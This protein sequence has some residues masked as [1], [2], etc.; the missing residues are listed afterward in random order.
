MK[1]KF[2]L[3]LLIVLSPLFVSAQ[4]CITVFSE[5]G[6]KFYLILN[7]LKQNPMP[8]TNVRVDGLTNDYY[9]AKIMFEDPAKEA[10]SK[11][12]PVKDAATG[13]FGEMTYK[14]KRTKD[15]ELKLRYYSA[16]PVPVNYN[17]PPDMYNMHYGDPAPAPAQPGTVTQTTVTTTTNTGNG[18]GS[19]SIGGGG[20]SISI[21]AQDPNG[22]V[23]Q[24][25][26]TTT[27]SYTNSD[28]NNSGYANNDQPAAPIC[29]YPMAPQDYRAAKATVVNASFEE[30]KLSTAKAILSSNCM[31]TAQVI[32][33][34]KIFG[35]EA[36]KLDF[37]KF[38]YPKTTDPGNYFKVGNVFSFDA[39]KTD[40]NNYI[41]SHAR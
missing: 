12:I 6:D 27:S 37:A 22:G 24:T 4:G 38:A 31:N 40:L 18:G 35:F 25:T 9:S 15:G 14:I 10:I 3:L 11:N 8:Q 30:T 32:E 23:S 2:T 20:V 41:S 21:N 1:F 5:D 19:I 28:G 17:P 29:Q 13:Q 16:T 39:S 33:I 7:G 34:C 26:T 36:S